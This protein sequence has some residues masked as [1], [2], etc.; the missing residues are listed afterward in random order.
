MYISLYLEERK[1]ET[2]A[3]CRSKMRRFSFFLLI[4]E[5]AVYISTFTGKISAQPHTIVKQMCFPN[6]NVLF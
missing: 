3:D 5:F 6:D 4:F 2:Y 1:T